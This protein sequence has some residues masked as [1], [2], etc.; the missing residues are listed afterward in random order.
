MALSLDGCKW[1]WV[2]PGVSTKFHRNQIS[3]TS[4]LQIVVF[5]SWFEIN[6]YYFTLNSHQSINKNLHYFVLGKLHNQ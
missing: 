1:L 3:Y 5:F 6:S 2:P 4:E